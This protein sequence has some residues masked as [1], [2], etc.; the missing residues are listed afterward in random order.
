MN[1]S[2]IAVIILAA[3]KGTRMKSSTPKLLQPVAYTPLIHLLFN[4]LSEL[5]AKYY[6]SVVNKDI[7]E[8]Q[9]S[10]EQS[11]PDLPLVFETQDEQKGTAHAVQCGMNA[12]KDFDGQVL[13]LCGDSYLFDSLPLLELVSQAVAEE[14]D[15]L[16]GAFEPMMPGGYGRLILNEDE[17]LE[18]IIE[19]SDASQ[20][21][22]FI[23]QLCN[24]GVM[25]C[26]A[27]M[28][29]ALLPKID[30]DNVKKEY[31]L[32]DVVEL[33]VNTDFHCDYMLVEDEFTF[34]GVNT[35]HDLNQ[36]NII[37]QERLRRRAI[38]NGVSFINVD[39]VQLSEDTIIQEGAVIHPYVVMGPKVT[40]EEGVTIKS[41]SH[42]ED[43]HI[44]KN[45]VVGPYARLRPGAVLE[46]DTHIG[47]FVEVKKSII[48]QGSKVNH[49]SYIGDSNIGKNTNIG[50]G[51]I[52][53][54]YDGKDKHVTEI[55]DN[56]FIGSNTI[57][58]APV[59]TGDNV[60]TAAG[61]TITEDVA[62]DNLAIARKRQEN[63]EKSDKG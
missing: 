17:E 37:H 33:A 19:E 5:D 47:N 29:K 36:V 42:I 49:L 2:E 7:P 27:A 24:S 46:E 45:A 56:N 43:A 34:M 15:L 50:A 9:T 16:I 30:N 25:V 10:L 35:L 20:E 13:I 8:I 12:L 4:Q 38:D 32:T 53:C 31:Y 57:F 63:K 54:N 48:G 14:T 22:L 52:T 51:T 6:V 58:V 23:N 61:S 39:T 62:S 3:G 59:K 28:L 60:I 55:G 41:F 18:A 44:K 26:S 1:N 21:E 40:I 11:F